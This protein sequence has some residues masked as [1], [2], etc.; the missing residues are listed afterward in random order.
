M[1]DIKYSIATAITHG[2]LTMPEIPKLRKVAT[3][4]EYR[5][6]E[7]MFSAAF[8]AYLKKGY[9]VT[10]KGIVSNAISMPYW[11]QQIKNPRIHN[12]ALKVLS[13]S[14]WFTVVT[15]PMS[16][17]SEAYLNETKLLEYVPKAQLDQVRTFEKF[18]DY[19]LTFHDVNQDMGAS[20]TK[21]Q[22]EIRETGL[23]RNGFAKAGKVPFR[24]DTKTMDEFE[25]VVKDAVNKGIDKMIN[26][27]PQIVKD[28]ANYKELGSEIVDYY[29]SHNFTYNAGPRTNDPRGRDNSGYLNRIG[30]PVG[31]KVMRSLL[32][33]PEEHR[34][35]VTKRG[36]Y[37]KFMFIAQLLGF[38]E[39][40]KWDKIKAGKEAYFTNKY[41]EMDY[42]EDT[43]EEV[44]ENMWLQRTYEDID[45]YFGGESKTLSIL[46]R[47]GK[48]VDLLALK[49]ID[50]KWK[51]P[52]EID[53]SASVLGYLGLL[54]NH[55][56]FLDRCNI[57]MG[58]L[59]DAWSHDVITNRKQF[60]TIMR[61]CYGSQLTAQKMWD[62]MDIP[63]T[64]EEVDAFNTE[65]ATGDIAVA[66]AF[67]N[68]IIDNCNMQEQMKFHV[69]NEKFDT[70]CNKWHNVGE[71]TK[72]F[73]V[74]N[75]ATNS[76]LTVQNTE[77]V[78]KADLKSFRR[79][80]V[81]GCIHNL[82]GQ[83]A[84]NT[85]DATYDK[86]GW[87]LPIHDALLLCCEAADYARDIYANGRAEDE[88]S[89]KWVH[90]NRNELLTNYFKS[91][92][93]KGSAVR[94]HWRSVRDLVEPLEEELTVN[95]MVLK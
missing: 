84:D 48:L 71:T 18:A 44:F 86:Y 82:D 34:N 80:T 30:N 51:V 43:A 6:V 88:P 39:G 91:I 31:F 5:Q 14:G 4:Q 35:A 10:D 83:V 65:M 67:K 95:P 49:D 3:K 70:F 16:N 24:F 26:L 50:Y 73:D 2:K 28:H 53:M 56:P 42:S 87:V 55:K 78:K 47:R 12:I 19:K 77:T 40:S 72:V 58:N 94:L 45:N 74:F 1:K 89:L 27:Y 62:L 63:Y 38:K 7:R 20:R 69:G 60:K 66:I 23:I 22:G 13:D 33:I 81:T 61:Q 79:Y 57:T 9:H 41:H 15:R 11:A 17:W 54:L 75:T 25:Y 36:L 8:K 29:I 76:I 68:F 46:K 85:T 93:I 52:I 59:T 21:V 32:V 37:N 64:A 92:G 90:T